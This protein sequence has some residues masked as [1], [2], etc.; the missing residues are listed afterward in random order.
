MYRLLLPV[1]LSVMLIAALTCAGCRPPQTEP[2]PAD[3]GQT[4][5]P[6]AKSQAAVP[7]ASAPADAATDKSMPVPA[8]KDAAV[9]APAAPALAAP[10]MPVPAAPAA[11]ALPP[12]TVLV[13]IGEK[14]IT[15]GDLDKE[16]KSVEKMMLQRGLSAQQFASMLTTFKPQILD[17]LVTQALIDNE[18]A[19]K[20]IA[21]TDEDIK[22]EIETLK[23]SLPKDTSLEKVLQQQGITQAMLEDQVRD[24]LKIEK[25][26]DV[27]VSDKDVKEF[28]D[29]NRSRFFETVSAR[30]ILIKTEAED[31]AAK[32]TA[33]KEKAEK[34]RKQIT[35]GGDFAKLAAENSDCPSK[36]FGGELKPPF[37]RGQMVKPFED[38][39]FSLK[40][41]EISQVVETDFG[42]HIIQVLDHQVQ[43]F[44][45]V[46]GRIA[47]MLKAKAS[48]KEA[49]PMIK[50][51]KGKAKIE[52]L[53]GATPPAPAM[54][55]GAG[56][57]DDAQPMEM[58]ATKVEEKPA[59]EPAAT[60]PA[61]T[62]AKTEDKPAAGEK[63]AT[64]D[65]PEVKTDAK[66]VDKPAD[67]SA[68]TPA[69][70]K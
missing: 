59:A 68:E 4:P 33:K 8:S 14:T 44:D 52:Y 46:K 53:N 20:K 1:S 29:E 50:N 31:D 70:T 28:Y 19:A 13:K 24:Q 60:A 58:P 51:L 10:A 62:P 16:T 37:R 38:V 34:L 7:A 47:A 61:A 26:L 67:K 69:A 48:M 55:P 21:I 9:P 41:N 30:H 22:K 17:G 11:P 40:T 2:A 57:A 43:P 12:E 45:E 18:C 65:K 56:P 39:A 23:T 66:P 32:K 3:K 25:L 54:F 63:A 6:A 5:D 15:Q 35:D 64:A 49:E 27:K 36:E 42:Y